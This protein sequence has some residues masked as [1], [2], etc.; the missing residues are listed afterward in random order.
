M[1]QQDSS[2]LHR[3]VRDNILYGRPDATEAEMIGES[4]L[5]MSEIEAMASEGLTPEEMALWELEYTLP[6]GTIVGDHVTIVDGL[7]AD[8]DRLL[9]V[10]H[11][12]VQG[13]HR[14]EDAG[15]Q[16]R[17]L[18]VPRMPPGLD[19]ALQGLHPVRGPE[20]RPADHQQVLAELLGQVAFPQHLAG[21]PVVTVHDRP[22]PHRVQAVADDQ[23]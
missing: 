10:L 2:L 6:D 13:A 18:V 7:F 14:V 16:H 3:S 9:V 19:E 4:G 20:V 17:Q 21:L 22:G 12:E 23:R 1:V 8:G 11:L 15:F 5:T